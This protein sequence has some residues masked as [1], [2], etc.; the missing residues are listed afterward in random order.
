MMRLDASI[1]GELDDTGTDAERLQ[2]DGFDTAWIGETKHDVFLR[3]AAAAAATDTLR[4]GSGVAIAFGRTPLTTATSA[5]D[6]AR[7][8][9]G[10]FT[11]GLG[12]QVK[13]HIERRF[14]MPWSHPAARMREYVLAVRAIWAS[15]QTG[16]DLDFR[17]DFYS[18]TLMPPFFRPPAHDFGPPPIHLAAVGGRMTEVAGEVCDGFLFHPFT[19]PRYLREVTV[20]ALDRGRAKAGLQ[21]GGV[22][23]CGPVLTAAGR[24][25]EELATAVEGVRG[26]IAFYASTPTYRPVLDLHGWEAMAGE[27]TALSKQGRWSEMAGLVD[28]GVLHEFAV[29][30]SP[31]EVA[32]GLSE[33]FGS[34]ADSV[35]FS[36]PYE[37]DRSIWREV[38][39]HLPDIAKEPV[40]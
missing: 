21:P 2:A 31:A 3:C 20:P 12:S 22:A 26:Q 9:R 17:G 23:V 4:V 7:Y 30:G 27:L 38:A 37:H 14:S 28:D 40:G 25:E 10:R 35:S 29:V 18:H 5:Y 33:R 11:L 24:T 13:A 16:S 39:S 34:L 1:N 32:G 36:T 19:T 15:W 6:L 8:S